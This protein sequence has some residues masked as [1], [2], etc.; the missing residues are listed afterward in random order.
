MNINFENLGLS[1]E[2]INSINELG[3]ERPSKIQE[4]MIPIIMEG[5]DAIGQAQTGTGKTLAFAASILTKLDKTKKHIQTIVLTPTRELA[6]QVCEEFNSLNSYNSYN[7]LAVY[8]GSSIENQIRE[9]KKNVSVVVGT[10]GRVLDLIRRRTL[11]IK[12]VEFLVLDEADEMLN[13]GFLEDIELI[14]DNTNKNKQVLMLSA[15]MPKDIKKLA[16]K[17]MREDYKLISI[18]SET[19]TATNVE[20]NYYL[21]NDKHRVEILC[22]VI[23]INNFKK[24][25][26]FCKTKKE[27]DELFAELQKRNYSCEIMHGDVVQSARMKTLDKF[28]SGNFKILIAT[29]VAARGI[30]VNDI[31]AVINYK[32]PQEF[33]TYIHRIGRTGR[34]DKSGVAISIISAK[35]KRFIKKIEENANCAIEQKQIP[36]FNKIIENKYNQVLEN[37]KLIIDQNEHKDSIEYIRDLNKSDLLNLAA[38]LLKLNVKQSIGSLSSEKIIIKER[39]GSKGIDKNKTRVFINAGAKDK[40]TKRV[41]LDLI[42]KT[43]KIRLDNFNNIEILKTFTFVDVNTKFVKEFMSNMKGKKINNRVIKMEISKKSRRK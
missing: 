32:L 42:Q 6:M 38:A 22:R 19:K 18:K 5:N 27:C 20:Q 14:L 35:E 41:L 37:T 3:Y 23:D 16:E 33:E 39:E 43:T 2:V 34:A 24:T 40:F 31:D 29:D 28:K 8:G 26:I 21:S 12:D 30:H 10:P 36:E 4:K 7:I 15:T 1:N 25:I 11:N 17:Y 13:M 9:L